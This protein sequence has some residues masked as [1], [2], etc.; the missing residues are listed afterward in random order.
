M[1]KNFFYLPREAEKKYQSIKKH[2]QEKEQS[3]PLNSTSNNRD[4][5][6][7]ELNEACLNLKDDQITIECIELL[8]I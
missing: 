5:F 3:E 4:E 2:N 1:I 8:L 6:M 7:N